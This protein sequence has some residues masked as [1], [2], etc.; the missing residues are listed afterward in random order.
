MDAEAKPP[1]LRHLASPQ[2]EVVGLRVDDQRLP[3]VLAVRVG[4][5]LAEA[6]VSYEQD[7]RASRHLVAGLVPGQTYA[8]TVAD[9]LVTLAPGPGPKASQ[10]GLLGFRLAAD[11]AGARP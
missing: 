6:V 2:A 11:N 1:L 3:R 7:G 9:G 8:V 5:P 10:A 4:E